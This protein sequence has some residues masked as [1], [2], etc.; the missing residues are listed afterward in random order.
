VVRQVL[1]TQR[2]VLLH[3]NLPS[4]LDRDDPIYKVKTHDRGVSDA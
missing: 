3:P 1:F 2:Q 4:W